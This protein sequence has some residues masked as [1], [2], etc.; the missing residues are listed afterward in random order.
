M[1]PLVFDIAYDGE[2]VLNNT[3]NIY[4]G[5]KSD[6]NVREVCPG[7]DGVEDP[8]SL[9]FWQVELVMQI[10]K[11]TRSARDQSIAI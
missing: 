7:S 1:S 10:S 3:I 11:Y 4:V 8:D 5:L 9:R 6:P 2:W